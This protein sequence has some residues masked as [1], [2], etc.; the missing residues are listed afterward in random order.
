MSGLKRKKFIKGLAATTIALPFAIRAC[1]GEQHAQTPSSPGIVSGKKYKWS[2][3]TTWPPNFPVVGEGC[4]L[5]AQWVSEMSGGR[6]EIKVYGGGEKV[7]ALEVFDAVKNGSAEMGS[8]AS[9]YWMGKIPSA[10]FF[11]AV[12]FGM[13][14]QQLNAWMMCGDGLK[15]WRELYGQYGLV[16]FL[17][18][19]TGVQ[20][21]GWFNRE[22]NSLQDLKGL[23]M[24]MPGLGASVLEKAGGT[25]VLLPGSDIYTGLERGVIEATEWIGPY[26]DYLMGF[27]QIA[28][29]YYRPGWHETCAALE[30][31]VNQEKYDSLPPD[32]QAI[33]ETAA[34]RLN[35][36]ML[37]EFEAK[38][39]IYLQKLV[40]EENVELRQYPKEVLDQLKVYTKEVLEELTEK[41]SFAKKVY[42]NFRDF[43]EK[44]TFW[45]NSSERLYYGELS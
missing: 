16:P 7:P 10:P 5:F 18:G 19:N 26:H 3:V 34:Y 2:M 28:K 33:I 36:W 30:I 15:L 20:M 45:S 35:I 8:G 21:G 43:K 37:S 29:Y 14:A 6:L 42:D 31:I 1:G 40:T 25:S 13:N 17:G 12:P 4:N 24:R 11:A 23:Q 27:H 39:S 32:L 22:I 38:N 41:D 9:Y 44:A